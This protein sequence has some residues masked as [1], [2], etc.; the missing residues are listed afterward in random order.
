MRLEP[1]DVQEIVDF[2]EK[3]GQYWK[4]S[5]FLKLLEE[6]IRYENELN[7]KDNKM[8]LVQ[9]K[10]CLKTY[11]KAAMENAKFCSVQCTN[12]SKNQ[13]K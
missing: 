4:R 2:F 7:Q 5:I 8:K 10:H 12:D 1:E 6:N 9:C 3:H 11:P 13:S